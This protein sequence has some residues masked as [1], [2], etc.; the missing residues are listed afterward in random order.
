MSEARN[1]IGMTPVDMSVMG[2]GRLGATALT[3]RVMQNGTTE[4][5]IAQINMI[6]RRILRIEMAMRRAGIEVESIRL[7]DIR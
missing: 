4:M 5:Q 3:A 7:D 6:E 2:V 1:E